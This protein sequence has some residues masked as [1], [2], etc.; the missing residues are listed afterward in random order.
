MTKDKNLSQEEPTLEKLSLKQLFG[1]LT[2]AQARTIIIAIIGIIGSA[3]YAGELVNEIRIKS[4]HLTQDQHDKILTNVT[5]EHKIQL[6][7]E[8]KTREVIM[9][10]NQRYTLQIEFLERS[11]AY[12]NARIKGRENGLNNYSNNVN[13]SRKLFILTLRRMY[14]EGD[15]S[16]QKSEGYEFDES[17]AGNHKIIFGQVKAYRIPADVKGDFVDAL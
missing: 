6:Q 9:K 12:L 8:I 5:I 15:R 14:K 3:F 4:S 11:H 13:E 1:M 10:E 7:G 16:L 2:V 17:E